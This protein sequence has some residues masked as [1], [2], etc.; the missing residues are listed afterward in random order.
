MFMLQVIIIRFYL[1]VIQIMTF[2][3]N[4]ITYVVV[5]LLAISRTIFQTLEETLG[6]TRQFHQDC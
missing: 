3:Y 1:F 5:V 4:T 6:R 2:I